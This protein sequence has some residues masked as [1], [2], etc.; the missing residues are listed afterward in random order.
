MGM[1]FQTIA[2][3]AA[4]HV[5]GEQKATLLS[6]EKIKTPGS[7]VIRCEYAIGTTS[8][9]LFLKLPAE[10]KDSKQTNNFI[11][12]LKGELYLAEHV[13]SAFKATPE[14]E[15]VSPAGYIDDINCFVTW[16]IQGDSLQDVISAGLLFKYRQ[17]IP[18]LV[19]LSELCGK[20]LKH[21]HS[22][23]LLEGEIDL[24]QDILSYCSNR[25]SVLVR[26][27]NS[28]VTKAFA[29]H[30]KQNISAWID[31]ALSSPEVRITLC[32][33][34]YSPHNIIVTEKGICVLDFS[35]SSAGLPAFDLAC[36]W[37]KMEDLKISL[38]RGR[39]GLEAIQNSFLYAY[40]VDFDLTRPDIKLG[41]TRLILSKMTTLLNSR[42]IR[43][44]RWIENRRRYAT[45]LAMLES[46][47]E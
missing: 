8:K 11:Q 31:D 43:P 2:E 7:T 20:W 22:L 44:D 30:L 10:N 18:E 47:F 14:L 36:F 35:Y 45:Y 13:K 3:T 41:L 21:F 38:L 37:H 9:A 33:N 39:K 25:I 26:T 29:E 27:N 40:G 1:N 32:H 23:D 28:R 19:A 12:Q 24:R 6:C 16:E 46:L 4:E 17:D 34:D 5:F 42:S 15:V